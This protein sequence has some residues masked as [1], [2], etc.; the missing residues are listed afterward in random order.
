[1]VNHNGA[2]DGMKGFE[3]SNGAVYT[4]SRPSLPGWVR[5][6][7]ITI[8]EVQVTVLVGLNGTTTSRVF[9]SYHLTES[10]TD[11]ATGDT[12][13]A[14]EDDIDRK[15]LGLFQRILTGTESFRQVR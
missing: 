2:E 9:V 13:T 10:Q 5:T 15:P 4:A 1:M 14:H 3:I 8:T 12:I 6:T 7:E 11:Q